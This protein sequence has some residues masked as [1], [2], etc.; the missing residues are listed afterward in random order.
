MDRVIPE[1]K[2]I[3]KCRFNRLRIMENSEVLMDL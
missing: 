1:I 3:N 2:E